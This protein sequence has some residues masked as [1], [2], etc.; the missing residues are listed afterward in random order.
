MIEKQKYNISVS[1][2]MEKTEYFPHIPPTKTLDTI[3]IQQTKKDS[4]R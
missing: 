2:M 4:E 3:Y 1:E